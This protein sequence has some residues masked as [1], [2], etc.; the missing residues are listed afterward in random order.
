[1]VFAGTCFL[2][3]V[4]APRFEKAWLSWAASAMLLFGMWRLLATQPQSLVLWGVMKLMFV[5]YFA[6]FFD[7]AMQ[8]VD[9]GKRTSVWLVM[10]VLLVASVFTVKFDSPS[11]TGTFYGLTDLFEDFALGLGSIISV[12]LLGTSVSLKTKRKDAQQKN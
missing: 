5:A 8:S 12:R 3:F 1:M 6:V 11:C 9:I 4:T 2:T 7:N 10:M